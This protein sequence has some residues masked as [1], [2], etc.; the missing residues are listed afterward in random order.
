MMKIFL[1]DN[2]KYYCSELIY[3]GF[4]GKTS[5]FLLT[6]MYFGSPPSKAY[7]TWENYYKKRNLPLPKNKPG[8]S[9][10]GIY[11]QGMKKYFKPDANIPFQFG[12]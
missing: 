9:P 6:P 8:I 7:Q 4:F 10:L 1:P 5:H 11:L 2:N 3:E 12:T